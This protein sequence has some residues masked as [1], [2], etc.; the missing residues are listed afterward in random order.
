MANKI[1]AAVDTGITAFIFDWYWY[2]VFGG[3]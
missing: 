3:Q 2:K 1:Q